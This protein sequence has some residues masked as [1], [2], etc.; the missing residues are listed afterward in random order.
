MEH[1]SNES[2]LESI[3]SMKSTLHK[4]E[5]ALAQMTENGTNTTLVKKRLHAI[6]VS[7]AVLEQVWNHSP[8]SHT[9]EDLTE[10]RKVIVGLLPS[11]ESSY[12]R[13]KAGSPQKTLL[14][15]RIRALH[16]SV[17]AID[18]LVAR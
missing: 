4:L 6:H 2:K 17:Q 14:E 7:L 3:Q 11:V 10:A 15:R 18:E 12:E 5:S 9:Q 8:L 16:Q 13:S 1:L